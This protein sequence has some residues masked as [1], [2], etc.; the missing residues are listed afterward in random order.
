M[1]TTRV[2]SAPC[3]VPSLLALAGAMRATSREVA[4]VLGLDHRT[5][6]GW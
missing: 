4:E 1:R 2:S 6:P 3:T 5:S